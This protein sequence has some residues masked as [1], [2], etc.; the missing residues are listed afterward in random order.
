[1]LTANKKLLDRRQI[2]NKNG[3]KT[4]FGLVALF[5]RYVHA[6]YGSQMIDRFLTGVIIGTRKAARSKVA[7]SLPWA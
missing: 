4:C 5:S 2:L 6:R 1:L 3:G 7:A